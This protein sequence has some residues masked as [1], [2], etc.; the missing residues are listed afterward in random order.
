MPSTR[1]RVSLIALAWQGR[2]QPQLM[3]KY[4]V[5]HRTGN[6]QHI[7]TLPEEDQATA[8]GNMHKK[9]VKIGRVVL[10]I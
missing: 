3:C 7:T 9:L 10:K 5:I 8:I 4:D 6:T 2:R 1:L